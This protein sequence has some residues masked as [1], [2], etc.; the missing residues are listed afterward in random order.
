MKRLTFAVAAL[1]GLIVVGSAYGQ[2]TTT[3]LAG[4]LN[5]LRSGTPT[6]PVGGSLTTAG[7]VTSLF[8]STTAASNVS[9][10]ETDL[11]TYSLPANTLSANGQKVRITTWGTIA[12]NANSKTVKLYFGSTAVVTRTSTLNNGSWVVTGLVAR[13]GATTQIEVGSNV[14]SADLALIPSTA[15]PAETLSGAVTI[16]VT[17]TSA[18]A[19][20]DVTALGMYVEW[21]P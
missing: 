8:T 2:D 1:I 9:T 11:I 15:S 17:G 4:F 10:T 12:A 21:V 19:S 18:T 5:A 20:S 13:T 16:K 14:F 3:L 7:I 6:V